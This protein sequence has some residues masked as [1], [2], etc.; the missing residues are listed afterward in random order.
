MASKK[1]KKEGDS[2]AVRQYLKRRWGKVCLYCG[3]PLRRDSEVDHYQPRR[4]KGKDHRSNYLLVHR[5]CNRSKGSWWT[6]HP[7]DEA[8]FLEPDPHR[9]ELYV[10][11]IGPDRMQRYGQGATYWGRRLLLK[12]TVDSK[13]REGWRSCKGYGYR[14]G[15]K[16]PKWKSAY[17][18]VLRQGAGEWGI[19][20]GGL[21]QGDATDN[22]AVLQGL[23][24]GMEAVLEELR[25]NDGEIKVVY[26]ITLNPVLR[27]LLGGG[28]LNRLADMDFRE[29]RAAKGGE[30][31]K[32]ESEV[33]MATREL[34]G[35]AYVEGRVANWVEW[36]RVH[37][38][39]EEIKGLLG[40]G[41]QGW[42]CKCVEPGVE[43][44]AAVAAIRF[45]DGAVRRH[46]DKL[47]REWE[48]RRWQAERDKLAEERW[49]QAEQ[50]GAVLPLRHISTMP[51]G[52]FQLYKKF[53]KE[54]DAG[55]PLE[56]DGAGGN[57][58]KM[59]AEREANA[60][61]WEAEERAAVRRARAERAA[62]MSQLTATIHEWVKGLERGEDAAFDLLAQALAGQGHVFNNLRFA[63]VDWRAMVKPYEAELARRQGVFSDAAG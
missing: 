18:W 14:W 9:L 10:E 19:E 31:R 28:K 51:D 11:G 43:R 62:Q 17:G 46:W 42:R 47:Q 4:W 29:W 59:I 33:A 6:G 1:V 60:V 30:L 23:I 22:Y 61:V 8:V 54:R 36:K 49:E 7:L 12:G 45:A 26:F 48:E 39:R 25:D 16:V 53:M 44:A 55:P 41:W 3:E 24:A 63:E 38:L 50:Y 20:G 15:E 57:D 34:M 13:P 21:I 27:F 37:E 2:P 56:D 5:A 32:P 35:D 40:Q 58:A 52:T